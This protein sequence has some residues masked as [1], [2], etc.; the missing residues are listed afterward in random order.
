[1]RRLRYLTLVA[2]I[3]TAGILVGLGAKA[4]IAVFGDQ[5][6]ASASTATGA[7]FA[8]DGLGPAV[9][10]S[11][12]SKTGPYLAGSI[13]QGAVYY[14]YANVT[15]G[16][17]GVSRVSADIRSLTAGQF[18]APLTAGSYSAGGVGYGWRS[19]SFIAGSPMAGGPYAYSVTAADSASRCRTLAA[20][21]DIDNA[22]PVGTDMQPVNNGGGGGNGRPEA[23]DAAV[24]TF[25]E[26][27]DP[28]SV[29]G[30]WTGISTNV[31]VRIT[32]NGADDLVTVWDASNSVQLPLGSVGLADNYVNATTTFGASGTAS[33]MVQA[34]TT[35]TVTLGTPSATALKVNA[36][37]TA[38]WT[39]SAGATDAATNACSTAP[40][41]ESG[42][43]DRN[44]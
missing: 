25:S 28:E 5:G 30:G 32:D 22:G 10:A 17:G 29:L 43:A 41:T 11:V 15:P 8:D 7:C 27:I 6:T 40:V 34:G 19:T 26:M 23:G 18:L 16:G 39:P 2:A 1:M 33:T 38:V 31:V 21:V 9:T 36:T 4:T 37:V 13:Q 24:Y 20:S 44:F 14:V 12:I 42:A 3:S 35:I